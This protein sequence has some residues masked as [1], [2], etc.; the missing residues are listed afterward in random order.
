MN[1]AVVISWGSDIIRAKAR[2]T[3]RAAA[4]SSAPDPGL[5]SAAAYANRLLS[6]APKRISESVVTGEMLSEV[7][8]SAKFKACSFS[9]S[10]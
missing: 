10:G 8:R 9:F 7:R 5:V 1:T 6:A 2:A 4:S 3:A